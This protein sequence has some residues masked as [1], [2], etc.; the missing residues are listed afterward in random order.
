MRGK[1][2]SYPPEI[3]SHA[4]ILCY[5]FN[6]IGGNAM[7]NDWPQ[8]KSLPH[9]RPGWVEDAA[10]YF[11]S[12]HCDERG[13]NVLCHP[14]IA[15]ALRDSVDRRNRQGQWFVRLLLLMPDHLHML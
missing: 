4:P 8:R 6:E 14:D 1:Q 5:P 10:L 7:Q 11:V 9:D 12:I 15:E 3:A 13:R 2:E